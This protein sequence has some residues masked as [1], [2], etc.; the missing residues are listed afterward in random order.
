MGSISA[1]PAPT[2]RKG[3]KKN[4][5]A[6]VLIALMLITLVLVTV[7]CSIP[8]RKPSAP[9]S[10]SE[11]RKEA[12]PV[13]I[14]EVDLEDLLSQDLPLILNFGAGDK[15]SVETL[16]HLERYYQ[17]YSDKILIRSVDLSL[18]PEAKEGFPA[19]VLPTQFFYTREGEPLP[20]PV[21]LSVLMSQLVSIEDDCPVF[22]LHEGPLSEEEVV[23]LLKHLGVM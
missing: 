8:G 2:Q 20:L 19:P 22:T 17:E 21:N 9:E 13:L 6:L 4:L 14:T 7:G 15:E 5:V 23:T 11:P 12:P 1:P 16:A 18:N 3:Q 10:V